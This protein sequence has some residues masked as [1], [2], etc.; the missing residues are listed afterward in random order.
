MNYKSPFFLNIYFQKTE[1]N[2]T[3]TIIIANAPILNNG[4]V[5]KKPK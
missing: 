5:L 4:L 2:A 3:K 1:Y